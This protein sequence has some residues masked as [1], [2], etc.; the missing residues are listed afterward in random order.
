MRRRGRELRIIGVAV[1]LAIA[2]ADWTLAALNWGTPVP[3]GLIP[4]RGPARIELSLIGFLILALG[5][6]IWT[7]RP[8][9]R[10][11]S[12]LVWLGL[13][14]EVEA[15][16]FE[17]AVFGILTRPGSLPFAELGASFGGGFTVLVGGLIVV[18]PPFL[19]P[20]GHLPSPAWRVP[21]SVAVAGPVMSAV[22]AQLLPGGSPFA[23]FV[24]NP[25][26]IAGAADALVI[27]I[28]VGSALMAASLVFG[29]AAVV[30]RYRRGTSEQR[31]QLKWFVYAATVSGS[32]QLLWLGALSGTAEL[33]VALLA[34]SVLIQPLAM[35]VA[36]LRYRL[37]D[38]DVLINR[39]LVYGATTA[40]IAIAFFAGIV[41]L[42]AILRPLISGSELA[43]AASTLA[44]VALFQPLR[45]RIQ[46]AVD[47]RFYRSRYDAARTLDAF[48]VRLRDEVDLDAVRAELV[49][50]VLRTVQP[51]H[52]SVWLREARA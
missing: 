41:I 28:V 13:G 1:A 50:A 44:S 3:V 43:V 23:P 24:R 4:L 25:L 14:L 26:G 15:L 5:V 51:A 40:G 17:Y 47:R 45:R 31:Q 52:A 46:D 39:T 38:I 21:L 12:L 7:H 32:V 35:T 10:L 42:Q 36:I 27:V 29:V 16:A 19:F 8:Q 48:S 20:D 33:G 9:N 11:A 49:G 34:G 37:Y 22:A 2:V 30:T 6:V 18:L